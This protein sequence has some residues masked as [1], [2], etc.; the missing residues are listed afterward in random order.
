VTEWGRAENGGGTACRHFRTRD[1]WNEEE[2]GRSVVT[3]VREETESK[4]ENSVRSHTGGGVV[5][6]N[7]YIVFL[8]MLN[9]RT[10]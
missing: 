2:Y 7:S 6:V 9:F 10:L 8:I 3:P 5:Q 1:K 4:E